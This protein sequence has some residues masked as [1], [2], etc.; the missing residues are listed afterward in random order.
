MKKTFKWAG[1][2][3]ASIILLLIVFYA[4]VYF[5]TESRFNKTY[6]VAI[7]PITVPTD[8]ESIALGQHIAG[9]KGCNGCHGNDYGGN[10][11]IDD[12]GLGRIV[13]PNLTTGKGGLLTRHESFTD[14]D[15]V[16]AI[17]HGIGK[18]NKTLK[19]MPSFEYNPLSNKDLGA[20]IA[21]LKSLPPVD[22]EQPDIALKPVAYV[23]THLDKLH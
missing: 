16:R 20:L 11:M 8:Q 22:K 5:K 18:D 4:F 1:I 19:L 2:I 14:E 13:A 7:K 3:L 15:Y 23:L 17:K 6:N 21:Y 9:I 12:P 10:I